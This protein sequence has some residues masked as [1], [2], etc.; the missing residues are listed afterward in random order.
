MTE[1]LSATHCG[2][3]SRAAFTTASSVYFH[4]YQHAQPIVVLAAW[5][6]V[7]FG[8]MV[9]ASRRRGVSPAEA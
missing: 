1:P 5:A 8:A 9:L 3:A 4:D 2:S 6:T 7:V